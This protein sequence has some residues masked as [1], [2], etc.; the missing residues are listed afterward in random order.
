MK[1]AQ[2]SFRL[3]GI[4][5]IALMSLSSAL[6]AARA[7]SKSVA[8]PDKTQHKPARRAVLLTG[9]LEPS[10]TQAIIVPSSNM[11]PATIRFFVAEGS[12]VKKGDVVLRIDG[13]SSGQEEQLELQML[14]TVQTTMRE[15]AEL[16]VRQVESEQQLLQAKAA[17]AKAKVD[18]SLPKS[19]IAALDFDKYRGERDRTE[20]EVE[21]KSKTLDNA[22]EAVKR[23]HDDGELAVKKLQIRLAFNQAQK[24][25]AEVRAERDG[26][27]IHGYDAWTGERLEEGGRGMIGSSAGQ[28]V[29]DGQMQVQT[30]VLE[31]D[32]AYL[33]EDQTLQV[34]FDALP[35][36]RLVG[37]IKR[38][39]SAPEARVT[40]GAGRYF[41]V[42]VQLPE[43]HG[44]P[45]LAGMSALLIPIDAKEPILKTS[46]LVPENTSKK[47]SG[48]KSATPN[49]EATLTIE[50]DVVSRLSSAISPP[51]IAEVWQYN[52]VMLAPDGSEVKAGQPIAVFE[53]NEVVKRIETFKSS[54]D[55][56]RRS[57]EK[58]LL[59][60]AEGSRA[61]LLTLNEAKSNAEKAA[62]KA[63]LP[64]ELVRR[65]E[66]DKLVID[67][68]LF[69]QLAEIAGRQMQ[70][71]ER[72]RKAERKGV[73]SEIA[74]LVSKIAGLEKGQKALTVLSPR[75][76]TV[77]HMAN[78]RGEK[79]AVGSKVF[80]GSAV[81]TLADPD[82]LFVS[83]K[84]PEAQASLVRLGQIAKVTLPG[85]NTV[86]AAKVSA[87]GQVFHG[88]ST[89]QP[90]VV[91]DIQLDFDTAPKSLK[92]GTAVQ[93]KIEKPGG[94]S[95]DSNKL[96]VE[97]ETAKTG[98][99]L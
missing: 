78:Y 12:K 88:K 94:A 87:L 10:D 79:Y 43:N 95:S 48:S 23:K 85:G 68:D 73:E 49:R 41:K 53:A 28:I 89:N 19:Q 92:P 30:W 50:G 84:L 1:L 70:A 66:Y 99:K 27:V 52:L 8:L 35:Q 47:N 76:G 58:L 71:Q 39:A 6:S 21:V 98:V 56:K 4:S 97:V 36:A 80:M 67:R 65:I 7:Q 13:E 75:A 26:I 20:R 64:K 11:S 18:A 93:I 38:I 62:R 72:A 44:L 16:E 34:Q 55:E 45:L 86:L 29:G 59:D 17:F 37:K 83:A 54:L 60:H 81:A 96:H 2:I 25:Q 31:A 32:R 40:W 91:R 82:K 5:L 3:V 63:S 24:K 69:A 14:Q 74:M 46:I 22:R 33:K 15:I 90:M 61:N 57:L 77:L 9:E 42:N 51:S